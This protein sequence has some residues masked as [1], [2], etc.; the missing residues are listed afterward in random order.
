[1]VGGGTTFAAELR[2]AF[3]AVLSV[4]DR[5]LRGEALQGSED[6]LGTGSGPIAVGSWRENPVRAIAAAERGEN[7]FSPDVAVAASSPPEFAR[8][9]WAGSGE[10]IAAAAVD[11]ILK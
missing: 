10:P 8:L 6:E 5:M 11:I 2:G 1:M 3:G 9:D 4:V 7:S